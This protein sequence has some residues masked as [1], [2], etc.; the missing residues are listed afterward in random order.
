MA[1]ETIGRCPHCHSELERGYLGFASGLFWSRDRLTWWQ[2]LFFFA[3][4]HGSFV[5]GSLL[6]TPWFRSRAAHRCSVCGALVI[7]SDC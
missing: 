3:F 6:S 1:D 4:A 7:P 2:S 5:V